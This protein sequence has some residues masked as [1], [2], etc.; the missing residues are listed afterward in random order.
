MKKDSKKE[1]KICFILYT[2]SAC[3]FALTGIMTIIEEG[4]SKMTGITDLG[5]SI[6]FGSLAFL[7]YKKY[8]KEK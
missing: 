5:L 6:A 1:Y 2:I 4:I 3:L 8:K 7:Y